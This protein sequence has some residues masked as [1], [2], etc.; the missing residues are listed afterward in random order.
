MNIFNYVRGHFALQIGNQFRTP[1]QNKPFKIIDVNE[2]N[3]GWQIKLKIST[4]NTHNIYISDILRVYTHVADAP[5]NQALTQAEID[6][7][8]QKQCLTKGIATY[9]IPLLAT[10]S[11]IE[12]VREPKVG[13]RFIPSTE[14]M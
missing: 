9:V 4:G 7:F 11:D 3:K 5:V 10:F 6:N 8:V 14:Q 13:V 2:T 1:A 12:V